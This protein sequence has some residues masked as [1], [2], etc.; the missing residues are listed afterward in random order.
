MYTCI[1]FYIVYSSQWY[2]FLLYSANYC[3]EAIKNCS[4]SKSLKWQYNVS[5]EIVTVQKKITLNNIF[6]KNIFKYM[7]MK[8]GLVNRRKCCNDR[9]KVKFVNFFYLESF[10]SMWQMNVILA[11]IWLAILFSLSFREMYHAEYWRRNFPAPMIVVK[12]N[13]MTSH[14]FVNNF[15]TFKNAKFGFV[16]L[17]KVL[18]IYGIRGLY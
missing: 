12:E 6:I 16:T 3:T 11:L 9:K 5:W 14:V 8:N 10:P 13:N 17:G 2:W 7:T 15:I 1:L 4:I 18:K